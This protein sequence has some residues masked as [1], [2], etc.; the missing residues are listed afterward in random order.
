MSLP[1]YAHPL[2]LP[3]SYAAAARIGVMLSTGQV[4]GHYVETMAARWTALATK[5]T[6]VDPSGARTRFIWA[7]R[8]AA[9][10]RDRNSREAT[11]RIKQ[12]LA[13]LIDVGAPR[14]RLLAEAFNA[15]EDV[16]SPLSEEEVGEIAATEVYWSLRRRQSNVQR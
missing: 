5:A 16:G 2:D 13:P 12:T 14:N 10:A 11:R 9:D 4:D 1:L 15:N 6:G 8:D 3:A 7:V